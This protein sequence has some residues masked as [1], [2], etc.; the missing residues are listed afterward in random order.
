MDRLLY[1]KPDQKAKDGMRARKKETKYSRKK[2]REIL[3]LNVDHE[4]SFFSGLSLL[5]LPV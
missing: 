2:E 3:A 1:V 5:F 4:V